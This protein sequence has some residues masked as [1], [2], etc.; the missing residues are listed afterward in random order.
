MKTTLILLAIASTWMGCQ[1]TAHAAPTS[2]DPAKPRIAVYALGP[3]GYG[4]DPLIFRAELSGTP[5]EVQQPSLEVTA[6]RLEVITISPNN[7]NCRFLVRPPEP[8]PPMVT[9]AA[10]TIKF[11]GLEGS[12]SAEGR[13]VVP[14]WF[15]PQEWS[16]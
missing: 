9:A 3:A 13:R 2:R 5:V 6:G 7:R 11:P 4:L 10:V 15:Y 12:T 14:I 16:H 8:P 1:V